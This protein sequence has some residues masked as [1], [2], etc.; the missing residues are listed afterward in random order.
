MSIR[1]SPAQNVVGRVQRQLPATAP[2]P[3]P[4]AQT[5]SK[6]Q[7]EAKAASFQN[8]NDEEGGRLAALLFLCGIGEEPASPPP[9]LLP[10]SPARPRASFLQSL[11][12]PRAIR[13][14]N[15]TRRAN[16]INHSPLEGESAR[17]SRAGG[18]TNRRGRNRAPTHPTFLKTCGHRHWLESRG[19]WTPA[20]DS[21]IR[22]HT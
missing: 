4:S 8:G 1:T 19:K 11:P 20:P 9:P 14:M 18:G 22:G 21:S 17:R 7:S 16:L 10:L 3:A 2:L 15:E 5:R 6:Q 12:R 13:L